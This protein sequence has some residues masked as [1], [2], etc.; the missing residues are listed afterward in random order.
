MDVERADIIEKPSA[1]RNDTKTLGGLWN[2]IRQGVRPKPVLYISAGV[3][4]GMALGFILGYFFFI[5]G[6]SSVNVNPPGDES[7]TP[8][9]TRQGGYMSLPTRRFCTEGDDHYEHLA[10]E[11][12]LGEC[13]IILIDVWANE[14]EGSEW[15]LHRKQMIVPLL[16]LARESGIT[17]I[18][19]FHGREVA[20]D[21]APVEGELVI[22]SS[23]RADD[24]E[25][26]N[27]FLRA[28][29][30]SNLLYAGYATNMCLINRPAGI[31]NMSR[32]DYNVI[33]L[34]DCTLAV[35][36]PESMEGHWAREMA[37]H[38]IECNWGSTTTLDEL[39]Q[40]LTFRR[41]DE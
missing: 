18:H 21:C 28:R 27:E 36:T 3:M 9:P 26:L 37:V 41:A 25:E 15:C 19:A 30:I 35:E 16:E 13:A 33:L 6:A 38:M 40:A 31:I 39:R 5:D 34:R 29:N 2:E 22:D 14:Q 4:I 10:Q 8:V 11:L 7:Y 32:L 23:N 24:K 1:P 20:A 17:V 12:P